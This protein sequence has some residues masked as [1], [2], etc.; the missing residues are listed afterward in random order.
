M[1]TY[2]ELFEKYMVVRQMT[3]A[4]HKKNC[5]R[6]AMGDATRG[7]GRVLSL[8]RLRDC[9]STKDI[10]EVMGIRVTSLNE[11]LGKMENDGL[12]ERVPSEDDKRIMLVKLTEAGR[13]VELPK[14]KMPKLLFGI[15]D[16]DDQAQLGAYFDRMIESLEGELGE[17][18]ASIMH[19][20]R[21]RQAELFGRGH[22][23][24]GGCCHGQG[25]HKGPRGHSEGACHGHEEHAHHQG[26]SCGCHRGYGHCQF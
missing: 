13:T 15:F 22:G 19:K 21:E 2:E 4:V 5:K 25:G 11:V 20:A 24:H 9:V 16:E 26:Q 6:G 3:E 17:D 1:A 18:A 8:L 14:R 10:A 23:G 7:R 12:I